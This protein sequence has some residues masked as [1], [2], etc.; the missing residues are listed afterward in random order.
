MVTVRNG[1]RNIFAEYK[2][3]RKLKMR[4]WKKRR[5]NPVLVKLNVM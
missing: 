3:E 1:K 2:L 4:K 5:K